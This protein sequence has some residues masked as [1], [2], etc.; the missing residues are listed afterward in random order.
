MNRDRGML[1]A[2]LRSAAVVVIV[3]AAAGGLAKTGSA[4]RI[5][6]PRVVGLALMAAGAAVCVWGGRKAADQ[7]VQKKRLIAAL[8]GLALAAAGAIVAIYAG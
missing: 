2:I 4:A 1:A 6:T 5:T 7:E 3:L 8:A